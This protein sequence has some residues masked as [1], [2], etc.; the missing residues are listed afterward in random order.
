V[1]SLT[2]AEALMDLFA[3]SERILQLTGEAVTLCPNFGTKTLQDA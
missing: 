3:A 1:Y 2:Q